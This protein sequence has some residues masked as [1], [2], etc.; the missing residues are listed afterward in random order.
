MDR[1]G[2]TMD[3]KVVVLA[4]KAAAVRKKLSASLEKKGYKVITAADGMEALQKTVVAAP[5]LLMVNYALPGINGYLLSHL[6]KNDH[7][8]KTLPVIIMASKKDRM[9]LEKIRLR[10]DELVDVSITTMRLLEIIERM[11]GHHEPPRKATRIPVEKCLAYLMERSSSYIERGFMETG[12]LSELRMLLLRNL[13]FEN[14]AEIALQ[15]L[16]RAIPYNGA[17]VFINADSRGKMI[18]KLQKALPDEYMEKM[19]TSMLERFP[20]KGRY[21]GPNDLDVRVMR[22]YGQNEAPSQEKFHFYGESIIIDDVA[23]GVIGLAL[24]SAHARN[25][26]EERAPFFRALFELLYKSV[27]DAYLKEQYL[28]LSTT[29]SLTLVNNRCRIIDA[30]K[31]ELVRAKRYFLDLSV[32]MFDIDNFKTINDFYGYQV[33]D[34]ILRD[35]AKITAETMRSIDEVGRYG[36]E[37]FL[38]VL[39]ETNLKNAGVAGNRLKT[40]VQN[41]VFPG[42]A[43]DIKITLSIGV[44]SYLRDIDIS[45]D[46]ILRRIDKS[47]S[48]AKRMGKNYVHVMSK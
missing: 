48:E 25:E 32:V 45:V 31:K 33:G 14:T 47:L 11:I 20:G 21:F 15:I 18:I 10:G 35:L 17:S 39:P 43:K 9:I 8:F 12:I 28:Q 44:T 27:E 23:K 16:N 5:H 6:L 40:K 13:G 24:P 22:S 19:K 36:G 41:H 34:L 1:G 30:L 26:I 7:N 42:I 2:Q 46:D 4:D 38:I 3:Q 29:D 37:E